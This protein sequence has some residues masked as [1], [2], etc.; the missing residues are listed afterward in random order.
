MILRV[1][2]ARAT[3]QGEEE[4]R[5]HFEH[6]VL[7]ELY[8]LNG[9]LR[10]YLLTRRHDGVVDIEVHTLWASLDVIQAFAGPDVQ[11][12]VVEPQARTALTSYD[13]TV[14]LFTAREYT[15]ESNG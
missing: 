11:A 10:A 7:R 6:N 15:G 13:T 14:T 4:Y 12:A 2:R 5:K 8:E 1:W 9:F 3:L